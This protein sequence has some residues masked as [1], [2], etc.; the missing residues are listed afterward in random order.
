MV[1][2]GAVLTN[3][4]IKLDNIVKKNPCRNSCKLCI[5]NCPVKA[6]DGSKFMDQQKC[7][8]YAFG[9]PENGGEWRIKCFKCR[10]IC[11]YAKGY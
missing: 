1:W 7:W 2:L 9:K 4:K 10:S 5:S 8:D 3:A 6:I 11:P